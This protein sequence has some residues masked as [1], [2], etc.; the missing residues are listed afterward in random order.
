MKQQLLLTGVAALAFAAP[1]A[2]QVWGPGITIDGLMDDW[3]GQVPALITDA[4]GDGGSGR[5]II[6]VY[7]ANDA[8][9]LYVRIQSANS[10]AFDGNELGAIDGDNSAATGFNLFGGGIGSDTL[11]AGA[12]LFGETTAVF[13]NGA[14]TPPNTTWAENAAQTDVEFSIPLSTTI[15]GDIAAAF[16]GGLG[17]TI[18]FLMGDNNGGA[19][20]L[21]GPA[22]YQLA[23]VPSATPAGTTV[24]DFE[25]FS[26]TAN[27]Q[28]GTVN[29]SDSGQSVSGQATAAGASGVALQATFNMD[30]STAFAR[31]VLRHRFAT[32]INLTSST[33]VTIDVAADAGN[34][35]ADGREFLLVLYELD[36]DAYGVGTSLPT[37]TSFTTL[38][39]P[40]Y[41]ASWFLQGFSTGDGNPDPDQI[42][43]WYIAVGN[44]G[45]PTIGGSYT[46]RFDNLLAP[47]SVPVE[48]DAFSVD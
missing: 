47:G 14:A 26:S 41:G 40:G 39:F 23:T 27:A 1:A 18:A 24:D 9:N 10:N 19:T 25:F 20:D 15:P 30:A 22:T 32:P 42:I 28:I 3:S 35:A 11:I 38:T 44:S 8:A 31:G 21:A 13:N 48:L 5:D 29:I 2:A 6:A 36:G 7:L 45:A 4:T 17:S 33:N 46:L 12:S 43:G 37:S 34:P 16:P